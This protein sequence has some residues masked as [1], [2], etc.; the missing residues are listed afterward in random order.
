[1]IKSIFKSDLIPVVVTIMAAITAKS[2]LAVVP[3]VIMIVY[4]ILEFSIALFSDTN[5]K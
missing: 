1:M 5:R 4:F 2:I 3:L